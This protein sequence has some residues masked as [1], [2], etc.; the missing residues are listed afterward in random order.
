[1][2][3][4]D[5]VAIA[6]LEVVD[7]ADAN[8]RSVV[9]ADEVNGPV[10]SV[11]DGHVAYLKLLDTY[12]R[13][14]VRTR[15][16]ARVGKFLELVAVVQLCTHEGN[17]IA[18]DGSLTCDRDILGVF[19]PYPHHALALVLLERRE[20]INALIGIG[21]PHGVDFEMII[22]IRLQFYRTREEG[23]ARREDDLSSTVGRTFVDGFLNGNGIVG[24]A[25]AHSTIIEDIINT[26]GL[27]LTASTQQ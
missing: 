2:V 9:A 26:W 23:L 19:G 6:Y 3:D 21:T 7:E 22:D 25:I 18:I 20:M 12:E 24:D 5:A 17:A 14:H 10:G 27:L 1:M 8:D 11:A 4:V 15:V 13:E 16:E